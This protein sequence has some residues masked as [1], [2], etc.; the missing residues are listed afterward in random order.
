MTTIEFPFE[1]ISPKTFLGTDTITGIL[2]SGV[3]VLESADPGEPSQFHVK[4]VYLDAGNGTY[5]LSPVDN[6]KW[7]YD[8]IV[9]EIYDDTGKLGRAA[10]DA[11]DEAV[12]AERE[13][14]PDRA[15]DEWR[16]HQSAA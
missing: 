3:A 14:D 2:M 10:Q 16:D 7:L 1:E 4:R 11:F 13:P 12:Q 9:K 8:A 5:R 15:Y 6:E